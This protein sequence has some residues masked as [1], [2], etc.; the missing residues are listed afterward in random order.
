MTARRTSVVVVDDHAGFRRAA[1]TLL[2]EMGLTVVGE[3]GTG[4]AALELVARLQP[5]I[6]LL[7][8]QL[9]AMDGIDVARALLARPVPPVVVLTSSRDAT[10]YGIRLRS[11]PEAVF[12]GKTDLSADSISA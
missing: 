12:I 10:D 4:E 3:A 6:V 7:D 2:V 9:P 8:V 11:V 1:H 5:D